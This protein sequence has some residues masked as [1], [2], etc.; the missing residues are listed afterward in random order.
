MCIRDRG[1]VK[2]ADF[3]IAKILDE[4]GDGGMM[5]TQS[6]AKLGT[7]PYIAPEQI[8]KPGSVDHRADIYSLGV[9]F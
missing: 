1:R 3:G 4:N 8:E 5:L 9:V 2:I 6:G 7:A